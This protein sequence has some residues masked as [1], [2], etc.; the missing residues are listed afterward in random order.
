MLV[1]KTN[2]LKPEGTYCFGDDGKLF[3]RLPGDA[4]DNQV[5]DLD[6]ALLV[7]EYDSTEGVKI[8]R[9]NADVNGDDVVD[10][11]DA[12]LI[13]QYDAGWDDVELI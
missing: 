7:L 3:D 8:N 6:D 12:L 5:V 1:E 2:G 9:F 11:N 13:M 10:I 4:D